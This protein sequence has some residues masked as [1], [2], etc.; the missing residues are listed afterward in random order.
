VQEN[1]KPLQSRK[2]KTN[3][4]NGRPAGK[5]NKATTEAREAIALFV[6]N[7]AHRLTG[8]LDQVAEENPEKAFQL[9][10]SVIEYHVPK[11]ARNEQQHSGEVKMKH[12]G[13]ME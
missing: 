12:Y 2:G 1:N 3:N 7:N 13:W 10:Q 5:P 6:D 4:P 8:W 11:L 9:F